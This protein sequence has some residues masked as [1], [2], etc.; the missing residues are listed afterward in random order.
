MNVSVTIDKTEFFI[1]RDLFYRIV[2]QSINQFEK[3][4][5]KEANSFPVRDKEALEHARVLYS[6]LIEV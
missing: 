6:Q 3:L 5:R 1:E 4:K 2:S